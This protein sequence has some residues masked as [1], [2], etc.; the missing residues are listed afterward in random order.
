M[1][2]VGFWPDL[3][4]LG[5]VET[6]ANNNKEEFNTFNGMSTFFNRSVMTIL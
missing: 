6:K 5:S 3:E 4:N 1:V 2:D